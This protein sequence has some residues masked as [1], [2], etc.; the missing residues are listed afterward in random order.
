[1]S[2]LWYPPEE[3]V[4]NSNV[5]MFME[6][7]GFKDYKN[8]IKKSV[9]DIEW[10]WSTAVEE[11]KIEWF[12]P[13]TRVLDTSQGIQWAKWFTGGRIN[14]AHNALDRHARSSERDRIAF[15]WV[16]EDG[17]VEK[18]SYG[19]LYIE[20]NRLANALE[21]LGVRKGDTV[22]LLLPMVPETI[23]SLYAVLKT[24]AIVVP[25]FSGLGPPAIATRLENSEAKVV[26]TADGTYR[27]GRVIK[28]KE[29]L[30][31]AAERVQNLERVVV[32]KRVGLEVPWIDGRDLWWDEVCKGQPEEYPLGPQARGRFPMDHGHRLDDGALADHRGSNPLRDP[33]DL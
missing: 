31:R 13:Y 11:L 26:I 18:H 30:D 4:E 27:R 33:P 15:I 12:Q 7:Y 2:G 25:I 29:T 21:G 23:V 1:M 24:G 17:V 10:F 14:V 16:G 28:L 20:A 32:S 9:E 6:K 5:K 19:D 8:L 22:A 3:L